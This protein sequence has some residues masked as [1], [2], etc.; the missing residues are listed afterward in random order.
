MIKIKCKDCNFFFDKKDTVFLCLECNKPLCE[1]CKEEHNCIEPEFSGHENELCHLCGD[2][3][4]YMDEC[5]DCGHYF[6][7]NCKETH[8]EE[9]KDDIEFKDMDYKKYIK[10]KMVDNL[11]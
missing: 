9:R 5:E 7:E 11:K 3:Q 2:C 1:K 4:E 8:I 6:C 10:S